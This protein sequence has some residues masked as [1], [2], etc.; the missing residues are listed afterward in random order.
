MLR[1]LL[2][3]RVS[4]LFNDGKNLPR[5]GVRL[6]AAKNFLLDLALDDIGCRRPVRVVIE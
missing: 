5:A 4:L 2:E 6:G 3:Q 1:F